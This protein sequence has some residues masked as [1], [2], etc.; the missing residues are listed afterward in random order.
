MNIDLNCDIGEGGTYDVELL[1]L[2]SSA[3]VACGFH[4]GDASTALRT[5]QLAKKCGVS[6]GAHP[7][8]KDRENFGRKEMLCP[9]HDV[10]ADCIY[11]VGALSALAKSVGVKLSH[12]KPH[13]ALYN[14][15]CREDTYAR[16][17]VKI[18][19]F[20]K[21]PLMGLPN[22]RLQ[23]LCDGP[24]IAEGFADRRYA[25]DGK[26]VPR[27]SSYAF[28]ESIEEAITQ[29]MG[30]RNVD[31]ICVHGDNPEAVLFV[32]ELRKALLEAGYTIEN[33]RN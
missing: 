8:F 26:L 24:F 2:V 21:L 31:S 11:Q 18:A 15:A 19:A 16:P 17:L 13:G 1:T 4:A 25:A 5:I 27:T 23:A 30:M 33:K 20:F 14:M 7:S 12:I 6:V 10:L 9:E 22:S 32:R 28:V 29:V 3:N